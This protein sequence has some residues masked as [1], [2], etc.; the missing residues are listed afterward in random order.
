[1]NT[2]TIP[3]NPVDMQQREGRGHRYKNHAV[4]SLRR[5]QVER[6]TIVRELQI[7]LSPLSDKK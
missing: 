5:Y 4:T 2:V 7:D 6:E 1:M 3:A